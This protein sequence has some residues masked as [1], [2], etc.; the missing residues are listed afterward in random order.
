MIVTEEV[1]DKHGNIIER[2]S[3]ETSADMIVVCEICKQPIAT[4]D[5][6]ALRQPLTT[7]MFRSVDPLHGYTP[8]FVPG[9]EFQFMTCPL[10]RHRFAISEE[11]ILT[12]KGYVDVPIAKGNHT[13]SPEGHK[14]L[15]TSREAKGTPGVDSDTTRGSA[16]VARLAHAQQAA[17]SSPAPAPNTQKTGNVPTGKDELKAQNK[18]SAQQHKGKASNHKGGKKK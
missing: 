3:I 7:D 2:R 17:G 12:D 11:R 18:T 13:K 16:E 15:D 5:R 14:P 9:V 4:T 6:D 8:P 1:R 10:C